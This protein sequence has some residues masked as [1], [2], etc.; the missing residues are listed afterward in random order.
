M[1]PTEFTRLKITP[2]Q[3]SRHLALTIEFVKYKLNG[4]TWCCIQTLGM[5]DDSVL[6]TNAGCSRLHEPCRCF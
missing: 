2:E 6:H 4:R 5:P 3:V 1:E